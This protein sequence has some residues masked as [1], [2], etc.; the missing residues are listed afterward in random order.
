MNTICPYCNYKA[1]NHETLDKQKNPK[2]GEISFCI[3]CGEISKFKKD[4]SLIKIDITSLDER[5]KVKINIISTVWLRQRAIDFA[6]LGDKN[7]NKDKG[8]KKIK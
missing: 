1:T 6:R 4:N 2:E 3:N 8:G 5:T 7:S